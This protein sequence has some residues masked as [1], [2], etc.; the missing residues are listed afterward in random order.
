MSLAVD[1][2]RRGEA[3]ALRFVPLMCADTGRRD[4]KR[5]A[6]LPGARLRELAVLTPLWD[7]D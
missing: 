2:V 4:G 6:V 7:E 3:V 1:Q 5:D